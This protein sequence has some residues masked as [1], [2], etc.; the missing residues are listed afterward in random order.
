MEASD[1]ELRISGVGGGVAA[2]ISRSSTGSSTAA[3]VG[4]SVV[5]NEID[6]DLQAYVTDSDLRVAG[7]FKVEANSAAEITALAIAGALAGAFGAK[8]KTAFGAAGSVTINTIRGGTNSNVRRSRV[9]TTDAGAV[10]ITAADNSIVTADAGGVAVS[11]AAGGGSSS[12][13]SVAVGAAIAFNHILEANVAATVDETTMITSDSTVTV[14]ASL[15]ADVDALTLAG[16]AGVGG[17]GG[18]GGTAIAGA[19]AFAENKI[20][21]TVD[22][23]VA[24]SAVEATDAISISASSESSIDAE[25]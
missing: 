20:I 14:S 7:D 10:D 3:G 18:G 6:R 2:S 17:S 24:D 4:A 15:D 21:G 22:A 8:G 11:I 12:A 23:H 16:A 19:G 13:T 25:T 1:N 5:L 9:R